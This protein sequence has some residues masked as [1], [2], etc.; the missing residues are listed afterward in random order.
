MVW[1][2]VSCAAGIVETVVLSLRK[3]NVTRSKMIQLMT[4]PGRYSAR[5]RIWL[6]FLVE[7]LTTELSLAT[8][9]IMLLLVS[10]TSCPLVTPTSQ[11]I[12]HSPSV[13][14]R[15]TELL[16]PDSPITALVWSS[17]H[18]VVGSSALSGSVCCL[19]LRCG[20][21]MVMT[22]TLTMTNTAIAEINVSL[23]LRPYASMTANSLVLGA[24]LVEHGDEMVCVPWL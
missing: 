17:S 15:V 11:L 6:F 7:Y 12:L 21:L 2:G 5:F 20:S 9:N 3:N 18:S 8:R 1:G 19:R 10:S 22:R 13:R 16:W 24:V 23:K 4:G 14:C